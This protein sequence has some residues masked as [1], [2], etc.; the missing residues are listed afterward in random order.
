M[1]RWRACPRATSHADEELN[2]P[3]L[4]AELDRLG[5][6]GFIGCEYRP[7]AG[8]TAGLGWLAPYRP[9]GRDA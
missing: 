5:Y 8:T 2:F 9:A 1:S 6:D 7:R 4:F 3:F